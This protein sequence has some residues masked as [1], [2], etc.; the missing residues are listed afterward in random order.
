MTRIVLPL[1][2]LLVVAGTVCLPRP[3]FAE[4]VLRWERL[5]LAV[6]LIVGQERVIILD[7]AMRVGVPAP[8]RER[9]RV[10]SAGG[11]LYLRASAA[12]DSTRLQ[13]QDSDS[14]ALILLDVHAASP[15]AGQPE[16]APIR[17]VNGERSP[18]SDRDPASATA[19]A[20]DTPAQASGSDTPVP[21]VLIRY[22]A[23]S[24]YAPLRTVEPIT[25]IVRVPLPRVLSLDSVLP[26]LPVRATALAAWRL[27]DYWVTAVQLTNRSA[28]WLDL[29]PRALQ[30]S[31]LAATFQHHT[32]GPHG[33]STDTTVLYLVTQAHALAESVLPALSAV[34]ASINLPSPG[35]RP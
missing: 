3:A 1:V 28:R 2:S 25:G 34:D 27:Q 17:I 19:T 32:L 24:L 6:P 10:Q 26:T 31:F 9:L 18:G 33:D 4:E 15:V 21:V 14:G 12:F 20:R 30:G 22:A 11:A 7:R 16:L 8:L 35:D 29:D 5:P 13:L 23:Q